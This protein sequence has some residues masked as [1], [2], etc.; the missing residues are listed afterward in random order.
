[1]LA[2]AGIAHLVLSRTAAI[3]WVTLVG[4]GAELTFWV[5]YSW[6]YAKVWHDDDRLWGTVLQHGPS[7]MAANNLGVSA[8][9][10]QDYP[11]AAER[12]VE[13]LEILPTYGRAQKNLVD[14]LEAQP[15][16][17]PPAILARAEPVIARMAAERPAARLSFLLGVL[18]AQRQDWTQAQAHFLQSTTRNPNRTE[19]WEY[20]GLVRARTGDGDGAITAYRR[21]TQVDP[22][23]GR[24][25]F[26]IGGLLV[27]QGRE[28]DAV[29]PLRKAAELLPS[30]S[31]PLR[32]LGLC[33]LRTGDRAGG[34][35]AL[36]QAL[37]RNPRDQEAQALLE[38]R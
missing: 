27:Q 15:G 25:W 22:A 16:A 36:R 29:V 11:A 31:E 12:F 13:A 7:A 3:R 37:V 38:S 21:A 30:R 9:E 19:A 34:M 18:A 5:A 33:L 26:A 1:V 28:A 4:T 14:V 10:R 17:L 2:G 23:N 35:E 6:T 24:A 20:L 32:Y 8:L